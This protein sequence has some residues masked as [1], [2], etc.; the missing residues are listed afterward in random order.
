[1]DSQTGTLGPRNFF[2]LGSSQQKAFTILLKDEIFE[3]MFA[4]LGQPLTM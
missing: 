3:K 4:Y 2:Q 1:M